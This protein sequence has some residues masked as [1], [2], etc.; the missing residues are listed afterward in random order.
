MLDTPV[1]TDRGDM[2]STLREEPSKTVIFY[3]V[4]GHSCN[5]DDSE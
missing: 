3:E 5:V 1:L 4:L 2:D